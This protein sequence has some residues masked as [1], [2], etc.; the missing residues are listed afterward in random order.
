MDDTGS[1]MHK[2]RGQRTER[3]TLIANGTSCSQIDGTRRRG[4]SAA[5]GCIIR[6]SGFRKSMPSGLAPR[7]DV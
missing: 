4:L 3:R 6:R 2:T 5:S 7:D 1:A